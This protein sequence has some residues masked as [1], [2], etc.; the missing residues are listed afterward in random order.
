M[1][2]LN[3]VNEY[4]YAHIKEINIDDQVP[5]PKI[6]I[7]IIEQPIEIKHNKVDYYYKWMFERVMSSISEDLFKTNNTGNNNED[8]QMSAEEI[9]SYSDE[10]TF[11]YFNSFN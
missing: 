6:E 11:N 5:E 3:K 10:L 4:S 2:S 9:N 1:D 8:V 7:D